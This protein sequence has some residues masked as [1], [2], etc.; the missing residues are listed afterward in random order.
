MH[1]LSVAA[2]PAITITVRIHKSTLFTT[3][4]KLGL[5]QSTPDR[6]ITLRKAQGAAVERVAY[7]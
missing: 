4:L 2:G 7:I 3:S 5:V 6:F 1:A